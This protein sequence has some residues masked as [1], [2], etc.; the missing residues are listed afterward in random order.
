MDT[1]I[2]PTTPTT[3]LPI[4]TGDDRPAFIVL[5]GGTFDPPHKGHV[6][7]PLR[8]RE[9]LEKRADAGGR[10]WTVYV[11]AA[12]SPHKVEGPVASDADRLAMLGLATRGVACT[13]VW[14][15]EIDRAVAGQPSYSVD[16]LRRAREWLDGH[17]C[18]GVPMRLLIG[19]DQ[20]LAFHKWQS[21]RDILRL[22]TPAV[23][24]RGDH[25]GERT[26]IN[27]LGNLDYYTPAEMNMWRAAIVP[28]GKI[29]ISASQ[30]REALRFGSDASLLNFVPKAVVEYIRKHNLYAQS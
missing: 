12:R 5:F 17:G 9:A 29:D 14:T 26:L 2:P 6:D 22:A 13:A 21:P 11:P 24:L 25:A 19:A 27:K 15:D 23:M 8:V 16:T 28:M 20:A 30:V 4:P 10:A 7:L 18:A 1:Q 3:P